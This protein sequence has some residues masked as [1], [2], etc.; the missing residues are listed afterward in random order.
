MI[1]SN[2][3][4]LSCIEQKLRDINVDIDEIARFTQLQ[5]RTPL[6]ITPLALFKSFCLL[7]F[8]HKVSL[9]VCAT[10]VGLTTKKWVSKQAVQKRITSKFV[11]FLQRILMDLI[12]EQTKFHDLACKGLFEPFKRVILQDSTN[13]KLPDKLRPHYPGGK[14]QTGKKSATMKIQA[15]FDLLSKTYLDFTLSPFT[16]NDQAASADILKVVQKG[17]LIIRDL[18]YFVLE[19]LGKI[20]ESGGYFLS[21][22]RYATGISAVNGYKINLLEELRK[23]GRLDIEILLGKEKKLPARLV[24]LPVPLRIADERRRK[25]K[26]NRDKRIKPNKE[27]LQLMDWQI[28]ITNVGKEIWPPEKVGD[29]YGL[30][31]RIEVIFKTWKSHFNL[32]CLPDAGSKHYIESIIYAKLIVIILFF[33]MIAD[34]SGAS[35]AR[36]LSLLRLTNFFTSNYW[37]ILYFFE[38]KHNANCFGQYVFKYC[39]YDKRKRPNFEEKLQHVLKIKSC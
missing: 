36:R 24:A 14:N 33:T 12:S 21:R 32:A 6:K 34:I 7:A 4:S 17:D 28:Y 26:I 3:V 15:V 38:A 10:F 13:I 1:N 31:W 30:R 37:I 20:K 29:I 18:G 2:L 22:Y 27:K 25:A 35:N 5:I 39:A 16:R 19:I 11:L 23:N 9:T 8:H